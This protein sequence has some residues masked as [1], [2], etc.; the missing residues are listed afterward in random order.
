MRVK[1]VLSNIA[2]SPPDVSNER[3]APPDPPNNLLSN[4]AQGRTERNAEVIIPIE[5]C[6]DIL[7]IN[8]PSLR[9]YKRR[10]SL[11]GLAARVRTP[12]KD[13]EIDDENVPPASVVSSDVRRTSA[14]DLGK[15]SLSK[16]I[17]YSIA[18]HDCESGAN[19][20]NRSSDV[21]I[22][23]IRRGSDSSNDS[24]T[25][26]GRMSGASEEELKQRS[27]SLD[28]FSLGKPLGKGKFGNVYMA[29]EKRTKVSI[30]LKVLFKAP[31]QAANCVCNLRREVE[32]QSR[33]KHPN[34]VNLFG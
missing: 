22:K 2:T 16:R 32:I 31:M 23:S 18:D 1:R 20:E 9:K 26:S 3:N 14:V 12:S 33:L 4:Y 5:Y 34:I 28:D 7:D 27:W 11:M 30:A 15:H 10:K 21:T 25:S 17:S 19:K 24:R 13:N 29:K 8:S 6:D